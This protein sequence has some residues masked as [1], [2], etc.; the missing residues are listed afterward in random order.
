MKQ[1]TFAIISI[2]FVALSSSVALSKP[3]VRFNSIL[4]VMKPIATKWHGTSINERDFLFFELG[5]ID[6]TS[7]GKRRFLMDLSQELSKKYIC[8]NGL[9]TRNVADSADMTFVATSIVYSLANNGQPHCRH[10]LRSG[11]GPACISC[12]N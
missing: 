9:A 11:Y 1:T 8:R 7:A 5:E 3:I 10:D 12:K 6:G 4:S 2:A